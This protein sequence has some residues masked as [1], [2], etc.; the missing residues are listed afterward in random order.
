MKKNM[1]IQSIYL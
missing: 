1:E